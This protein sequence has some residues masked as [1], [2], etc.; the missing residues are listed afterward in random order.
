MKKSNPLKYFNDEFDKRKAN[1]GITV[2]E[3]ENPKKKVGMTQDEKGTY[4]YV[5]EYNTPAGKR[6][7]EAN[8][9][10]MSTAMKIAGFKARTSSP[11]SIPSS[12][13]IIKQKK[14]GSVKTKRK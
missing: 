1:M 11:D 6:Y 13:I 9:P 5:G 4:N 8:S 2:G 12:N 7:Y 14:G 3:G 10:D